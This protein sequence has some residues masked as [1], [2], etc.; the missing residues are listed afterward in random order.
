MNVRGIEHIGITV[1]DLS[2]AEQFFINALGATALYHIVPPE[3]PEKSIEGT[4]MKPLN[5]FPATMKVTGLVMLRLG[6]GCNIELF[7]T[8]PPTQQLDGNINDAG[9]NHFSVYVDD[10]QQAGEVMRDNGAEMF[11]GPSDCFAQEEGKGN[12]TWFCMT[13]FGVLI[14]LISLPSGVSCDREASQQRWI[15]ATE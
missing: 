9:V 12:Q 1:T 10:I 3:R 4:K 8:A 2:A 14:E 5:G 15:P 11:E 7:Q 13:P 6:N